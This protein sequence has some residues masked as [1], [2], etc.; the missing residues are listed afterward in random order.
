M[1][2]LLHTSSLPNHTCLCHTS[3][4]IPLCVTPVLPHLP[5]SYHFLSLPHHST[6]HNTTH[7]TLFLYIIVHHCTLIR[8]QEEHYIHHVSVLIL[9][10]P[11]FS[12]RNL[13]WYHMTAQKL[14]HLSAPGVWQLGYD[15]HGGAPTCVVCWERTN[16]YFSKC[17]WEWLGSICKLLFVLIST[18]T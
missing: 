8:S 3:S 13:L 4:T 16:V 10:P 18:P 6:P 11:V 1:P 14:Y 9:S 5:V 15:S 2:H 12:P 17:F 7:V